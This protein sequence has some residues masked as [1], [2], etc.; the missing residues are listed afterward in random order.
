M[1]AGAEATGHANE[2]LLIVFKCMFRFR[3]C[4]TLGWP[5][6]G[7]QACTQCGTSF[8][9]RAD[10]P[11]DPRFAI[12]KKSSKVLEFVIH[13]GVYRPKEKKSVRQ[14]Y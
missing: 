5:V 11:V 8:Q 9:I 3:W 6:S 1:E 13:N 7:R 12:Q 10:L 4:H 2:V 14:V